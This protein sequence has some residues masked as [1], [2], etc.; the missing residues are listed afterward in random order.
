MKPNKPNLQSAFLTSA[1][2]RSFLK[3]VGALGAVSMFCNKPAI[4]NPQSD[5]NRTVPVDGTFGTTFKFV[6]T[7]TPGVFDDPIEGVGNIRRL[8][9]CTIIVQQIADFRT[10]P[11][12]IVSSNW[13]LTFI[14]GDQLTVS[15]QGTGTPDSTDPSFATLSGEGVFTGGTGRFE[16]ASGEL[17]AQGISHLD[18]PPGVFPAEGHATFLLQG[19]LRLSKD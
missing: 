9:L 5:T 16:N 14:E 10:V 8:G 3:R 15:F 13:V 2:R 17:S 1:N 7:D 12:S 6:P 11:P 4:A 19:L 18:T